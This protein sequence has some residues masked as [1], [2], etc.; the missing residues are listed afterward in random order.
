MWNIHENL[1]M[2]NHFRTSR[3]YPKKY[4]FLVIIS[5]G[6]SVLK[7]KHVWKSRK[8]PCFIDE[9]YFFFIFFLSV[10]TDMV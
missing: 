5:L 9:Y 2:G 4:E 1:D 3:Y 8:W 10:E 7:I 6:S